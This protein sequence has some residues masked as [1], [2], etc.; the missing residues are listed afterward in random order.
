MKSIYVWNSES[1]SWASARLGNLTVMRRTLF[2]RRC[3][4]KKVVSAVNSQEGRQVIIDLIS[5]LKGINLVPELNRLFFKRQTRINALKD[6]VA[7][8][9]ICIL[10]VIVLTNITAWYF[11]KFWKD[12]FHPLTAI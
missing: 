8:V 1:I 4:F 5:V 6:S 12:I 11:T 3:K 7:I 10:H 2:C 9:S